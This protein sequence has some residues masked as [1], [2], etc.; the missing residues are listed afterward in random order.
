MKIEIGEVPSGVDYYLASV[1]QRED[2]MY[3]LGSRA[4]AFVAQADTIEEAE[5]LAQQ[6]VE[7]VKGPVFYRKDIGTQALIQ[8][9]V[10]MMEGRRG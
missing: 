1:D 6:A 10:E 2:G 3:M 4:I 7:G 5:K 9:R 8:G